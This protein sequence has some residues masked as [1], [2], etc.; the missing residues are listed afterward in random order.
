MG[1]QQIPSSSWK[2]RHGVP[3]ATILSSSHLLPTPT[4][5]SPSPTATDARTLLATPS[6]C[7][8]ST[9]RCSLRP[10]A[11]ARHSSSKTTPSP[12]PPPPNTTSQQPTTNATALSPSTSLSIP[13]PPP[14]LARKS[15]RPNCPIHLMAQPSPTACRTMT[16]I[17]PTFTTAT[18]SSPTIL[19]SSGTT[20]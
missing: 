2:H 13:I 6:S 17:S 20:N 11:T 7:I 4:S 18:P 3:G 16:S 10:S 9:I 15:T 1:R 19:T 8:Q 5:Y 14:P 12:P